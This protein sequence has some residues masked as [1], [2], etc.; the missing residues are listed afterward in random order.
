MKSL[1]IIGGL[2]ALNRDIGNY[3]APYMT[4][5]A[6]LTYI[7]IS[8]LLSIK[9]VSIVFD[10]ICAFCVMEII[11]VLLK[12]NKNVEKYMLIGYSLVVFLPTVFFNSACWGQADSIYTAFVLMALLN[13]FKKKYTK[14][15]IYLGIAFSFKLQTVFILPLYILMY[16]SERKF[17]AF[18][19]LL[20]PIANFVMCLPSIIFGKSISS[21]I[22][23]YIGQTK[24][25][26][27]FLTM[28]FPNIYGLFFESEV[29]N[30]LIYA[31]TNF[32]STIGICFTMFL[33]ILM[34]VMVL[35]KKIKFDNRAIIEF[36]IWSII[37]CTFFLPHMHDRYMYMADL[38]GILYLIY[39]KRKFFIPI[40][41]ELVSLSTYTFYLFKTQ[42][43]N[44]AFLSV[45]NFVILVFYSSDIIKRYFMQNACISKKN[46][47]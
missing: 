30:N 16:I 3:N 41:I 2:F 9:F 21:C 19:F 20:I 44:M 29:E 8:P 46:V 12:N 37:I 31:R 18:N 34:A 1:K 39:N 40:A 42:A 35:Y 47:Q 4:I 32:E 11:K 26:S 22:D 5:L 7:P 43:L 38:L 27:Q 28:N 6:L 24:A 15:F 17:S 10:Y 45:I 36:G 25:Y 23:V 33:F 13:L 14:S